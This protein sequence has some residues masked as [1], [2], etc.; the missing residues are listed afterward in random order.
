M[1]FENLKMQRIW[2][3]GKDSDRDPR[4]EADDD[5]DVGAHSCRVRSR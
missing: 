3:E 2:N 1:E 4:L 5:D